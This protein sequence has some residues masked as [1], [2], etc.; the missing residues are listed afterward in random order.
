MTFTDTFE[1]ARDNGRDRPARA[2][3]WDMDGT[4]IDSEPIALEAL[5]NALTQVGVE[6]RRD[7]LD[8]AVGMSADALYAMVCDEFCI[9]CSNAEWE[10][11]KHEYYF[12]NL[13]RV[14]VISEAVEVWH[15]LAAKGVRQ[16]VVTNSDR[17]I[18]DANLRHIQMAAPGAISVCRNDVRHGKPE[19][20]PYLRAAWLLGVDPHEALVIEDSIGGAKSGLTAGMQTLIVPQST[21]RPPNGATKLHSY[22][23]IYSAISD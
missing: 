19:P 20:E 17:I 1:N 3:L 22:R 21:I 4:L 13:H 11:L 15:L 6:P 16:A 7:V 23:E 9:S 12:S 8:A 10:A 5:A 18:T 14:P 2:V